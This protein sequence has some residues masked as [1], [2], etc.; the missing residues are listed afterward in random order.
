MYPDPDTPVEELINLGPAS[1]KWLHPV[2]VRTL[3]DLKAVPLG[4][5]YEKV[6][7]LKPRC[8]AVFLYAVVGALTNTH[9]NTLPPD[10]KRQLLAGARVV[11]EKLKQERALKKR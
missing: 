6:K 8:S 2:G 9:W 3:A 4:V 5:L 1:G 11:N 10:I 7:R